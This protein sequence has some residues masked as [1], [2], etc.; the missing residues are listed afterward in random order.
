MALT[1]IQQQIFDNYPTNMNYIRLVLK[2]MLIED[3]HN[4]L[5]NSS[6]TSSFINTDNETNTS[7]VNKN[8]QVDWYNMTTTVA[9]NIFAQQRSNNVFTSVKQKA[10]KNI[11]SLIQSN[12]ADMDIEE[13]N[14]DVN[15]EVDLKKWD[16]IMGRRRFDDTIRTLES[17]FPY[18]TKR[19]AQ[20]HIINKLKL[21]DDKKFILIEAM[22]GTGKSAIAKMITSHFGSGYILTATKQLQD[23]YINEFDGITS[24]KG[25]I[26]YNC[27]LSR[28]LS[29][30]QA[31]C[32]KDRTIATKCIADKCCP[33]YNAKSAAA[34]SNITVTSYSFFFTWLNNKYNT[35]FKPRQILVLDECHLLDS[36][37]ASWTS[38]KL[39][40]KKLQDKFKLY[41]SESIENNWDQFMILSA[42]EFEEGWTDTNRRFVENIYDALNN[43][44]YKLVNELHQ[45][46]NSPEALD[47][48]GDEDDQ[49]DDPNVRIKKL[50]KLKDSLYNLTKQL[51]LFLDSPN[52]DEWLIAPNV[53]NDGSRELIIEPLYI[54]RLF[55][56]YINQYGIEHVVFMSATILNAK[57]FCEELGI[58]KD[59]V[60]IIRV[61]SSFD[62]DKSP[63][64]FVKNVGK[65]NYA[66]LPNTMPKIIKAVKDI[67]YKHSDEKGIIHTGN[68][69]IAQEI[70]KAIPDR[71]LIIKQGF[72]SNEDL[73]KRHEKSLNGVL[74]SPSLNTG[75]DLKDDLSRFQIIVKM[76]FMSLADKRIKKK[77]ELDE[78]WYVCEMLRT[79]IQASGRSTR[80]EED[81]SETYILDA[82]FPYWINKYM[83]WLPKQFLKRIHW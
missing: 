75:T 64:Y 43:K 10:N 1:N 14:D 47:N 27:G 39:N 72:E 74:V 7:T 82:S 3:E 25:K 40:I 12:L 13:L 5:D 6:M 59:E 79:L 50:L 55:K 71:R 9:K 78:R 24:I 63:I 54:S 33:Y 83:S 76:P 30:K 34:N 32:E 19:P 58:S 48:W 57:L 42:T 16:N 49:S 62:P 51:K 37:M 20:E 2:D 73:L 11:K 15:I 41:S 17:S 53:N 81:Y 29:C 21:C 80:S 35:S 45:F 8:K 56:N 23:Q 70:V 44:C 66:S 61:D 4:N 60:G 52:K 68:Y 36:Q 22:P 28:G 67:L 18:P 65:M 31:E 46:K 38:M 77:A 26:N 69:K